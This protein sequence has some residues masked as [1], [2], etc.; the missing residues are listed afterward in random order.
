[1]PD[2]RFHPTGRLL[3]EDA[4]QDPEGQTDFPS[5]REGFHSDWRLGFFRLAAE[6]NTSH[7]SPSMRFWREIAADYLTKLC[8][9]PGSEQEVSV[10]PPA[11]STLAQW[12]QEAPPMTGGEYL[13]AALLEKSFSA[14][15]Q[16]GSATIRADGGVDAFLQKRAPDWNRVGR[17]TFHLAEN[18]KQASRP[19]AF[20]ASF[21]TGIGAGGKVKHLPLGKALELYAGNRN[22]TALIKLLSPVNEA[23]KHL[24]WVQKLVDSGHIYRP[25][26]WSPEQA[27]QLLCSTSTL[28]ESGLSVKLPD[29]W[30]KRPRPQVK[31]TIGEKKGVSM[32]VDSL[33]DFSVE[34]ALGDTVLSPEELA[35]ILSSQ[36]GL[37]Q[38]KGQWVE[39]DQERLQQAID[40]W[41][42]LKARTKNGGVSFVEGMRMLAGASTDLKHEDQSEEER[43]W[44]RVE[45]GAAMQ[46]VLERLHEPARLE[47]FQ[48][49]QD[50]RAS[51]R[52]YQLEGVSW[53]D[54]LTELGLGACLADDM[55]LGKTLQVLALLAG[56]RHRKTEDPAL[57]ILPASLLGNW[58]TEAERFTPGLRLLILHPSET[59]KRTLTAM[60]KDP[61]A[62]L[63]A[64]DLVVT[65]YSMVHRLDWLADQP[66][67]LVILDEAQAVKNHATR[68]SRAVKKLPSQARIALTGTPIENRL[69]DLWSLFDFLNPGLLGSAKIFQDFVKTMES[70]TQ[71][72]FGPLRRL[73]SPYILRRLK[74]DR[75]II[76]D[77]PDKTETVRYCSLTTTQIRYY[78]QVVKAMQKGLET[79]DAMARRG[80][81]LQTLMRLKQ[82]C[83]HPS[84]FTGDDGYESEHSGKF[85]RIR[86]ICQELAERQ[87]KALIFTQF[88][89]IIPALEEHLTRIF[90]HP[91]LVLHG[92]TGV[93]KRKGLVEQFQDEAGPPFFILSLKAGGTGLNLTAASHVIHFDRWWN[94]AVEN[95][96]TDRAF[97]IGQNKNVLVHKFVTTGTIEERIHR[98]I[99]EKQELAESLLTGSGEIKLTELPDEELLELVRL[100]VTR[101]GA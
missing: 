53:L 50:L 74:T 8:H 32:G 39:V 46:E 18:T 96:A 13:S 87:E 5:L 81:V 38:L 70:R 98:L 100:D 45:A 63:G 75:S 34:V 12:V 2:I 37:V 67:S 80:L 78:Q 44:V 28:K 21:S 14:L 57:L 61:Q 33:L 59:D 97:R 48:A 7:F 66:W 11:E 3:L 58:K 91:G 86:E 85:N 62:I 60:G 65:T 20:M 17:V 77:L 101:A 26:A 72:P 24:D 15:D 29:W 56:R 43:P 88:K 54:F 4:P 41:N 47:A 89:E 1:M 22:K 23:A 16:W 92:S 6:T 76:A 95:Q 9:L 83:N 94:P 27:Y 68:Q 79:E 35:E 99:T 90:G 30:K 64:Y 52:S 36:G 19:F 69:S 73:V 51:L 25:L 31:A 82:I 10:E 42:T 71:N 40:H 49:N 84:Q 55:G 93:K